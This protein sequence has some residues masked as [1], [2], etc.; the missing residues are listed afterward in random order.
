MDEVLLEM[1]CELYIEYGA[2]RMTGSRYA[3]TRVNFGKVLG[4]V[5]LESY[6][7]VIGERMREF[8]ED[9]VW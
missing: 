6:V 3:A 5:V 4:C 7:L 1:F 9:V 2:L 8:V